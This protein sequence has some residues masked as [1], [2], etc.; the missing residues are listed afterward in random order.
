VN[1]YL[2]SVLLGIIE[3]LTEFLPV[4][5]TAH[6]RIAE[7]LLHIS[8]TDGYW[9]M[10]SI[11]I[12]LGAI[13][14][15]PVY[16]RERLVRFF[17]T[18]PRDKRGDRSI[19]MHPLSLTCVAFVVTAIPAFLLSKVI[20]KLLE[21]L[22]IMGGSLMI[23]GIVMWIVDVMNA[24]AAPN[25]QLHV[26]IPGAYVNPGGAFG[27]GDIEVGAK[28]R[29]MQ[30]SKKR[31]EVG[32]FPLLELPTG[33]SRMGLGNGQLW[34]RLPLRVQK[35]YGLWTTYGGAGYQINRAPGMKD[36]MFAGWLV[37]RQTTKRLV[38]GAEIYHQ[39]AQAIEARQT[40]FVDSGGYYNF[41]EKLSL[42]F[43]PG[44]TVTGEG[45][46]VG[47]LGL[48]YTWGSRRPSSPSEQASRATRQL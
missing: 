5:S 46:T 43:M 18:F 6:L 41:S 24:G 34:A 15:L 42:L 4:S 11:V 22:T 38:L 30:E 25:L 1:D 9:K 23:G 48:Y 33:N 39:E 19:L 35:S 2:V 26:A 12:Q 3:G 47:Y 37:Q 8:L 14:C 44:R 28:Y 27:I 32:I 45:H 20:G 29:F 7:G 31:P 10:Y 17:L 40:T 21:S 13:I 16:F 36:S